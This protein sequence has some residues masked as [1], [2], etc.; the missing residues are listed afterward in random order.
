ME[1]EDVSIEHVQGEGELE[2]LEQQH[3]TEQPLLG[4]EKVTKSSSLL[5]SFSEVPYWLQDN[6]SIL[7]GYRRLQY[8][9]R[10]CVKSMFYIHNETGN[11]YT[12]LLG[13]LAFIGIAFATLF[14][15]MPI[16]RYVYYYFEV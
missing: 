10:G 7:G 6:P 4:K 16:V 12:H 8:T 3:V 15:T 9:Y 5:I 13:A 2:Q 14:Y 1:K 11:I